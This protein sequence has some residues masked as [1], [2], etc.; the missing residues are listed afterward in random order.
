MAPILRVARDDISCRAL[1]TVIPSVGTC[2]IAI[3]CGTKT[4]NGP[5]VVGLT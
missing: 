4:S 2:A 5:D 3:L 1:T